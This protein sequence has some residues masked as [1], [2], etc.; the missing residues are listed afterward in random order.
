MHNN[1]GF[2]LIEIIASSILIALMVIGLTNIFM[3]AKSY[4]QHSRA[5]LTGG[6]L[7]RYFLDPLQMQVREDQWATNCLG[8][9]SCSST[10]TTSRIDFI[11]FTGNFTT[12]TVPSTYLRKATV[13]ISWQEPKPK[14]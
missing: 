6:E 12:S 7:G 4:V 3:V 5:R 8:A 11:D 2:T 9:S 13:T 1:K 10:N 14:D